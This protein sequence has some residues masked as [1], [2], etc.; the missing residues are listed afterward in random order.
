[1]YAK[2]DSRT[3]YRNWIFDTW[4]SQVFRQTLCWLVSTFL[5]ENWQA[6]WAFSDHTTHSEWWMIFVRCYGWSDTDGSRPRLNNLRNAGRFPWHFALTAVPIFFI[7]FARTLSPYCEQYVCT[8]RYL[9]VY[10]LNMNYC[11]WNTARIWSMLCLAYIY[12]FNLKDFLNLKNFVS[13]R[14]NFVAVQ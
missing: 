5:L 7:S 1:M 11:T 6:N 8:Y 4:I 2:K 12:I 3:W 9:T 14:P 10:R 13:W